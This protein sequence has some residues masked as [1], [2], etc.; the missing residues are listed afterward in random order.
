MR[1]WNI[2]LNRENVNIEAYYSSPAALDRSES[3]AVLLVVDSRLDGLC[4]VHHVALLLALHLRQG[5]GLGV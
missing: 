4:H 5:L 2:T 3:D 1:R